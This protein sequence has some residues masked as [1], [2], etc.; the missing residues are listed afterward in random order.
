MKKKQAQ[1]EALLVVNQK[2]MYFFSLNVKIC[3]GTCLKVL[4]S[5]VKGYGGQ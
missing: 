3:T 2:Q 1:Q 5:Q 4:L